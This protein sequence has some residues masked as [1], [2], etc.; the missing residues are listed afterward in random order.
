MDLLIAGIVL[1][2]LGFII[3]W[4]GARLKGQLQASPPSFGE[5]VREAFAAM[6]K[7]I[8]KML[9]GATTGDRVEG[10]GSLSTYLGFVLIVVSV[11]QQLV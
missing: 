6:L 9:S 8:G 4:L 3:C 1:I 2:V 11:V 10:V 7:S 5:I